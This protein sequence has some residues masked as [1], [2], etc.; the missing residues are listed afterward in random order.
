[1]LICVKKIIQYIASFNKE[2]YILETDA[3][4]FLK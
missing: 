3:S 2:D 4:R 1:M